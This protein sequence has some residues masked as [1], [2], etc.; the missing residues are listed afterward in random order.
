MISISRNTCTRIRGRSDRTLASDQWS[1]YRLTT[2]FRAPYRT[3]PLHIV[4]GATVTVPYAHVAE[5][6]GAERAIALLTAFVDATNE[7]DADEWSGELLFELLDELERREWCDSA[8]TIM[9]LII[10][11]DALV[12]HV[13][14]ENPF[15][16]I[17][18]IAQ[19]LQGDG[20][21]D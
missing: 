12:R 20:C 10:M 3:E 16:V 19:S 2:L 9:A 13:D 1:G 17:Q 11:L 5:Q 4:L 15:D 8:N 14:S 6:T 21:D 7:E 18:G